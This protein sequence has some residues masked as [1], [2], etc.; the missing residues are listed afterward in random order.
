MLDKQQENTLTE[1]VPLKMDFDC[2]FNYLMALYIRVC[3]RHFEN[4]N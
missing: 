1:I 4:I 3:L 2:K